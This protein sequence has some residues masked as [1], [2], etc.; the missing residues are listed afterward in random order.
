MRKKKKALHLLTNDRWNVMQ[1]D[2]N[3]FFQSGHEMM[4]HK[5]FVDSFFKLDHFSIS[6]MHSQSSLF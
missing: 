5:S 3:A 6:G 1:A 2:Y 4:Y